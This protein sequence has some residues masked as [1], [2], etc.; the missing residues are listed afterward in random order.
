MGDLVSKAD[1]VTLMQDEKLMTEVINQIVDDPEVM[2]DL[3]EDMA[4]E[5][6]DLLEDDPDFKKQLLKAAM[7]TADFKKRTRISFSRIIKSLI[8]EKGDEETKTLI[9]PHLPSP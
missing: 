6:A 2:A 5:L 1:V 7:G 9:H 8:D 3:A 4:D